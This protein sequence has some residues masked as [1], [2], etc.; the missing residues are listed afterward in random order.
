MFFHS[1]DEKHAIDVG[2]RH[3]VLAIGALPVVAHLALRVA[4]PGAMEDQHRRVDRAHL[5]PRTRLSDPGE[6]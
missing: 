3:L 6:R 2:E 1:P 5:W 4:H